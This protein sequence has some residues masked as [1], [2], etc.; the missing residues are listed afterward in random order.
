[1]TEDD[2]EVGTGAGR[3]T[4]QDEP[5]RLESRLDPPSPTSGRSVVGQNPRK[6]A[7]LT[8]SGGIW[9]WRRGGQVVAR[10]TVRCRQ[11]SRSA[12]RAGGPAGRRSPN[13]VR[14]VPELPRTLTG[15]VQRFRL[16]ESLDPVVPT[17]AGSLRPA[18]R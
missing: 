17:S 16:R 3:R 18:R 8:A 7:S 5:Q 13:I 2:L 11:R 14:F 1:M 15:K 12:L 6:D 9:G 4:L 10:A